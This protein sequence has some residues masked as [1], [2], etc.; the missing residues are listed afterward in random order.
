MVVGSPADI[1]VVNPEGAE[2]LNFFTAFGHIFRVEGF[3]RDLLLS[4]RGGLVNHGTD[5]FLFL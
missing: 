3:I 2:V 1:G 5:H 4:R